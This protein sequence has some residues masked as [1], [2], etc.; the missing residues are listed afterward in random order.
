MPPTPIKAATS[1][2]PR[3]VPGVSDIVCLRRANAAPPSRLLS[4]SS[5]RILAAACALVLCEGHHGAGRGPT[6]TLAALRLGVDLRALLVVHQVRRL[7]R[8]EQVRARKRPRAGG[9]RDGR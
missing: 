8:D 2:G 3:R 1:Y 9:R 5:A 4:S 7:R 6:Q